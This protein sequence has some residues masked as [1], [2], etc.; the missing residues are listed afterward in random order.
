M[1]CVTFDDGSSFIVPQTPC[2]TPVARRLRFVGKLV[3]GGTHVGRNEAQ[4]ATSSTHIRSTL[5]DDKHTKTPRTR[6][7]AIDG[8]IV[9]HVR[10]RRSYINNSLYRCRI[11]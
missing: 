3:N 2:P 4:K 10:A 8:G 5:G 1:S 6:R 11:I 7:V 9:N